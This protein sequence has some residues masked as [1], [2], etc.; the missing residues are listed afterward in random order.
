MELDDDFVIYSLGESWSTTGLYPLDGCNC[1]F[2][3][4]Y[5]DEW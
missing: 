3:F 2:I 1:V 5:C 4:I